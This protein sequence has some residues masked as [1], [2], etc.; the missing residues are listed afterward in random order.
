MAVHHSH[1][2]GA[3]PA[4][5]SRNTGHQDITAAS[6]MLKHVAYFVISAQFLQTKTKALLFLFIA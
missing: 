2:C 6:G 5:G 3:D 4:V 1:H